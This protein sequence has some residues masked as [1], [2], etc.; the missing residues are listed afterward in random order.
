MTKIIKKS[1]ENNIILDKTEINSS[2]LSSKVFSSDGIYIKKYNPQKIDSNENIKYK[3]EN[4]NIYI[5]K[6]KKC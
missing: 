3:K 1:S 6:L 4:A 5:T 2:I